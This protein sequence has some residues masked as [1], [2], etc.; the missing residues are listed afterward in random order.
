[1]Q[2]GLFV[3]IRKIIYLKKQQPA[4]SA[5]MLSSLHQKWKLYHFAAKK[6]T[7]TFIHQHHIGRPHKTPPDVTC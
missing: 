1:M 7:E 2:R 3:P 6:A 5:G 4:R